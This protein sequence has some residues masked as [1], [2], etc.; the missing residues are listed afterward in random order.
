MIDYKNIIMTKF[1]YDLFIYYIHISL[2]LEKFWNNFVSFP[3]VFMSWYE[4]SSVIKFTKI[5][6]TDIVNS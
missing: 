5:Y 3:Q 2:V 1:L 4:Y 6:F